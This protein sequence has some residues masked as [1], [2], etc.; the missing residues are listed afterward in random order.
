MDDRCSSAAPRPSRRSRIGRPEGR[1]R[2]PLPV[3]SNEE[4]PPEPAP[5]EA[6][7]FDGA[8][9]PFTPLLSNEED[10]PEPAPPEAHL[11]D[12]VLSPFTLLFLP[13]QARCD[14]IGVSPPP[15][16]LSPGS[17]ILSRSPRD[18]PMT[19]FIRVDLAGSF[20][21][22][23]HIG[24]PFLSLQEA[25]NAIDRHL[26]DRRDKDMCPEKLSL[27]DLKV[28]RAL[29]WPDGKRKTLSD[30][31]AAEESRRQMR[32]LVQALLDKYNEDHSRVGDLAYELKDLMC[33]QSICEGSPRVWYYHLNFTTKTKEDD[34]FCCG[35]ENLVFAEVTRMRGAYKDF[36]LSCL[37][38]L[39]PSDNGHCYGC[40]NNGNVKLKHPNKD[41]EYIGGHLDAHLPYGET[42]IQHSGSDN[43]LDHEEEEAMLQAKEEERVKDLYKCYSD[44][45][46]LEKMRGRFKNHPR[47]EKY[48]QLKE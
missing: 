26:D 19:F 12:G 17:P 9:S 14:T 6:P 31:H 10:P 20:H 13:E 45:K 3:P 21:V 35:M 25:E 11:F 40:S 37:Y 32:L 42:T 48:F 24:G 28:C 46:F 38:M 7:L 4:D 44:P 30:C 1:R 47:A 33:Y 15:A 8:L 36:A 5:A 16:C 22:Y 43:N 41:E 23:P 27:M 18:W 39:K 34:E 29:Y 2:I